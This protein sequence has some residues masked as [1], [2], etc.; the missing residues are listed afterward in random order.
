M[1]IHPESTEFKTLNDNL[2]KH[3]HS[4]IVVTTI[5]ALFV[6]YSAR[7]SERRL[8][9]AAL[10]RQ[11]VSDLK[12]VEKSLFWLC[13]P[14]PGRAARARKSMGQRFWPAAGRRGR[15]WI[16]GPAPAFHGVL[17]IR[18]PITD[19]R[20]VFPGGHWYQ[21]RMTIDSIDKLA[22][23][24][25]E[26]VPQG[27]RSV[28]DDLEKN[29]RTVLKSGLSKLDLVTREEFEVQQAVLAKT[30]QNLDA[31]EAR[32]AGLETMSKKP[33]TKKAGQKKTSRK[34]VGKKK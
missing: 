16:P 4:S 3:G 29:F 34:K 24:L 33:A 30:R 20:L 8:Y 7:I 15:A 31:L 25:A 21:P 11:R 2:L 14:L 32:L 10:D 12:M 18:C 28:S 23:A 13:T 27:L 9:P 17:G 19:L 5:T 6:R 1:S 22:R 26:A